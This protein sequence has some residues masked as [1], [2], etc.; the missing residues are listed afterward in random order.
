MYQNCHVPWFTTF[1]EPFTPPVCCLMDLQ[2]RAIMRPP[3]DAAPAAWVYI[4][5]DLTWWR[6]GPEFQ[7]A[8]ELVTGRL[9]GFQGVITAHSEYLNGSVRYTIEADTLDKDGKV[10]DGETF[11]ELMLDPIETPKEERVN[12]G[13]KG[14]PAPNPPKM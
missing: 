12:P 7:R 8:R 10:R 14:G 1:I 3:P 4:D 5:E 2:E 6:E 11:D 9:C 13:R